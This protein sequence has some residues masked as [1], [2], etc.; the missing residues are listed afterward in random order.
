MKVL[1]ACEC[2]GVVRR[3]FRARGHDAW[4]CDIKPSDDNSPFHIQGNVLP[5]L[6]ADWDILIA[7]P[8]CRYLC[9]SGV[10]R[11]YRNGKKV[12]GRDEERWAKMQAAADFYV[13]FAKTRIPR[14]AIE[15]SVMHGYAQAIVEPH[16]DGWAKQIIQPHEFG[17]DASKATLLRLKNLCPLRYTKLIEPRYVDGKPRWANQ[18]DSG[19]NRLPPSEERSALRAQ[20][21]QV[22]ADAMAEQWG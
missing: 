3:A 7:H 16:V 5:I 9:N 13:Q 21:Y 19:Q 4:S 6:S 11:L 8:E 10:L 14:V 12:N 22:I 20:T 15:N 2:S 17:D 18:T 1:L